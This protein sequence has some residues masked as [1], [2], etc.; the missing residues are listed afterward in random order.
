MK[1][2]LNKIYE[3]IEPSGDNG[4][5]ASQI[6]DIIMLVCIVSS[7]VPIAMK[8]TSTAL[9]VIDKVTTV[10]FILDYIL[11]LITSR[12]KLSKGV[13][14]Y[15]IYPL[16]PM[17]VIDLLSILPSF[18][19]INSG[20]KALRLL[21]LIRTLKAFRSFKFFRY[22]RN[23][24]RII[25]VIKK[26][27]RPLGAV[28]SLAVFYVLFTALIMFNIEPDTFGNFFDAIY[29]A[30][31]SLT[32]VGYGDITPASDI[33]R[34]FTILSAFMGVAIIA[35][36]SGIITAGYIDILNEEKNNKNK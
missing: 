3:I 16:T 36:P 23:I 9:T 33:G 28:M 5:K 6:Y 13:K 17:A 30:A 11:R 4:S 18:I 29:W 32:S 20:F 34:L 14:S 27:A 8:S 12:K 31:I 7:M 19:A 26:E 25:N 1:N 15:F 2:T 10:V 24:E 22:S 35:L 21:R